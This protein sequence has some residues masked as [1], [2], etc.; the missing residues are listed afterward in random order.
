MI[1]THKLAAGRNTF[2]NWSVIYPSLP[3]STLTLYAAAGN[4]STYVVAGVQYIRS[5]D[6]GISWTVATTPPTGTCGRLITNGSQFVALTSNGL[7]YSNDNGDTWSISN[8]NASSNSFVYGASNGSTYVIVFRNSASVR[9]STDGITWTT[10]ANVLPYSGIWRAVASNGTN[11]VALGRD[12]LSTPIY[13]T[14]NDGITW[15]GGPVNPTPA[16]AWASVLCAA[17]A[18][19]YV[20]AGYSPEAYVM[21]TLDAGSTWNFL[22]NGNLDIGPD[23][24]VPPQLQ[25]TTSCDG[26]NFF[27]PAG[28]GANYANASSNGY[29]FIQKSLPLQNGGEWYACTNRSPGYIQDKSPLI[30]VEHKVAGSRIARV[31]Y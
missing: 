25:K 2:P 27:M 4:G 9:T 1:E 14:S 16:P 6:N 23:S 30:F 18:S 8:V 13:A 3:S 11:F 7:Y 24:G 15:T 22:P 29:T 31:T 12:G 19:R 17:S 20:G 26:T 21:T 28:T 5:T 10:H